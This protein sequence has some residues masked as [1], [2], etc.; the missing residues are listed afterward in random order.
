MF[1]FNPYALLALAAGLI[2]FALAGL[3]WSRR[4][5]RGVIPFT[6]LMIG[7]GLW[8]MG[9]GLEILSAHLSTKHF[10]LAVIYLGVSI[11]P[12]AWLIFAM[13][14]TDRDIWITRTRRNLWLLTIH[15]TIVMLL[16][17]TNSRF[18]L[19]WSQMSIDETTHIADY[20]A[21]SLFWVHAAY[22]YTLV[23]IATTLLIQAFVRSPDQYRGQITFLMIGQFIPWVANAA[24]ILDISP[25]PLYVD[26]TPIAYT[27]TGLLVVWSVYRF[28]FM[29]ITPVAHYAIFNSLADAVFVLDLKNR[30]VSANQAA[31]NLLSVSESNVIGQTV[32]NVFT[33]QKDLLSQYLDVTHADDEIDVNVRGD[34]YIFQMRLSPLLDRGGNMSGRTVLLHDITQ[35]KQTNHALEEAR[36]QADE[37]SRLKSEF[38]ATM[39][40]EL[41]TPL[42]AILGY[43]SLMMMGLI[44]E[45]PPELKSP[46]QRID[47]NGQYL[48]NMINNILDLSKIEAGH[49]EI[50]Q[51]MIDLRSVV[52][53][54]EQQIT[55]LA[56]KKSL[57]LTVK[58]DPDVPEMVYTDP[59]RLSQIAINLLSNAV[60]FT[61]AG[62]VG[63]NISLTDDKTSWLLTIKD[64]G[65]GIPE[66]AQ[67]YIFDEFRQADGSNQRQYGGTGLGLAIV[68]KLV[69][70]LSGEI[71]LESEPEKGSTFFVK[72]PLPSS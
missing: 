58:I 60:K 52:N 13:E 37:A 11:T 63:L 7:V 35:L 61:D 64:T 10:F 4:P 51:T 40:H 34:E 3:I 65:I 70:H 29:D 49:F 27:L 68:K 22:C 38:L 41:R 57:P 55:V 44:G 66:E 17:I 23:L 50:E 48:L 42:S 8:S 1:Y 5:G 59:E 53:K 26:L 71:W 69:E 31:L 14:Y 20:V 6:V 24:Y 54:W 9:S 2:S 18:H 15:P 47:D 36:I 39:S 25:L 56:D 45:I 30:I 67:A 32:T 12:P 43:S 16:I 33:N 21:T 46:I 62:D 72:F 28:K 19:F